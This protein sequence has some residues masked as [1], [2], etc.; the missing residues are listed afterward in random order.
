[1]QQMA[2]REIQFRHRLPLLPGCLQQDPFR[3]SF[4]RP[5]F[6]L[7]DLLRLVPFLV[8]EEMSSSMYNQQ[9]DQQARGPNLARPINRLMLRQQDFL[10]I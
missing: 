7:V 8:L 5:L 2:S 1:M 9:M 10:L 4:C 3:I 6:E